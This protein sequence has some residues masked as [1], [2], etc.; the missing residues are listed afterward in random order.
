MA[1]RGSGTKQ[2]GGRRAE[3][4]RWCVEAGRPCV[5]PQPQSARLA[6]GFG[7]QGDSSPWLDAS[8]GCI[9]LLPPRMG[10]P[11]A[12][13]R[14]H[15]AAVLTDVV[16]HDPLACSLARLL[17]HSGMGRCRKAMMSWCCR[18]SVLLVSQAQMC[19]V[20]QVARQSQ[21]A[22]G[23]QWLWKVVEAILLLAVRKS[24]DENS[25]AHAE[26]ASRDSAS[27]DRCRWHRSSDVAAMAMDMGMAMD[28]NYLH[29]SRRAVQLGTYVEF[30]NYLFI[31]TVLILRSL[32]E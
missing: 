11:A 22:A 25:P 17:S 24:D 3:Y 29:T 8:L 10:H 2:E 7:R 18:V 9:A 32:V 21:A 20:G 4:R 5:S 26:H 13:A 15:G 19:S 14:W 12:L 6:V 30:I 31:N 28:T 27:A 1:G 23:R 16:V